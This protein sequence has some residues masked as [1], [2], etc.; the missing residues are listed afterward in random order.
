MP[1]ALTFS[2]Y[3]GPEVLEITD[4]PTPVP[5]P[6][7]LLIAV[8]AAAVNPVDWKIRE[9][10]L[11]AYLPLTFP[12]MVGREV[13]GVVAAVGADVTEFAIGDEV[14]GGTPEGSM[15]QYALLNESNAAHKPAA[16]S[17]V[18]AA[19]LPVGSGVAYDAA[20]QLDLGPADTVLVL[21]AGG[22]VGLA[23][24][25][26]ARTRGARVIGT[27]S[28]SKHELLISL[29]VEPVAYGPAVAARISALAP[30]GV[31]AIVDLVGAD[32]MSEVV[33]LLADPARLVS[34]AAA[35]AATELG[36]GPI[37]RQIGRAGLD[38]VAAMAVAGT[39]DPFVTA[40]YSLERAAEAVAAVEAGHATGKV[41]V[42]VA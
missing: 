21:G 17:F 8:R 7:Q 9:G 2:H 27:A 4:V 33:T 39:L 26:I 41:V 35:G 18:T 34:A 15:A 28:A 30:H 25:Q 20:V 31:T 40:T 5:G 22:G 42:V 32:A 23:M 36:G 3:G 37:D 38:A 19:A 6:G 24:A 1:K 16:L 14:F 10:Y 29:G 13:A 12:A 11:Q